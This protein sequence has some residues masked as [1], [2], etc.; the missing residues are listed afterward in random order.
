MIKPEYR[1]ILEKEGNEKILEIDG[2]DCKILRVGMEYSGH[3]C[4]YVKIP[5]THRIYNLDYDDID[6]NVH[7]GLTY[8]SEK[9]DGYWIGFD[10][11]HY[12]DVVP[13]VVGSFLDLDRFNEGTYKDMQYVEKELIRLVRQIK[14]LA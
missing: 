2:Y 3:L 10:C 7:G 13:C 8:A 12:H 5:E 14:A 9:K 4:G 1:E 6:V 11:A